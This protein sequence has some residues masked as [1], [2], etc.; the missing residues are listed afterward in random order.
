MERSRHLGA[1]VE[2]V[3]A[4]RRA[5]LRPFAR[6]EIVRMLGFVGVP[7]NAANAVVDAGLAAGA[8]VDVGGFLRILPVVE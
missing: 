6:R 4:Q 7:W 8:I 5:G 3:D 2:L 1:V